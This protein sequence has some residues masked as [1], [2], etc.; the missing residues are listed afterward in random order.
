MQAE[1]GRQMTFVLVL[2]LLR[3]QYINDNG[4]AVAVVAG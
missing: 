3:G 4:I 1:R 2:T